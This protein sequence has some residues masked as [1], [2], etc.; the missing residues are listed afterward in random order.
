MSRKQQN[1]MF[2]LCPPFAC[3][4]KDTEVTLVNPTMGY[5]DLALLALA[6]EL[7]RFITRLKVSFRCIGLSSPFADRQDKLGLWSGVDVRAFH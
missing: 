3:Q 4:K 6:K 7:S 5:I 2:S 1:A